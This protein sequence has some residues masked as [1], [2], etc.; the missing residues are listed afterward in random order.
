ML[1]AGDIF[2]AKLRFSSGHGEFPEFDI[3]MHDILIFLCKG[4]KH[5]RHEN[6]YSKTFLHKKG[7]V[8]IYTDLHTT[9]M[10]RI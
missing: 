2:E 7:L 6:K 4:A 8:F 9:F 5:Y 3:D 10:K 1:K